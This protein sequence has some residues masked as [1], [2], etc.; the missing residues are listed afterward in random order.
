MEHADETAAYLEANKERIRERNRLYDLAR[1]EKRREDRRLKRI[2]NLDE[3]RAKERA[4]Y[5]ANRD[6]ALARQRRYYQR[7]PEAVA[8]NNA[9]RRARKLNAGGSYTKADIRAQY[10]RQRGKCF[11]RSVSDGCAVNLADG[12]HVDHV[13]PFALG[14]GN[15]PENLV[16]ACP[17]CNC[18]KSDKHPM[19]FAGVLF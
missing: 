17:H 12:Y 4:Y 9:A 13:I 18:T 1:K 15:G 6:E 2:A 7:H 14:G 19:D 3:V 16:L 10:E 5:A 8:A 11:W